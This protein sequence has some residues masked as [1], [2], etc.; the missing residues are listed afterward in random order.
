MSEL[1]DKK[2]FYSAAELKA[3]EIPDISFYFEPYVPTEGIMLLYG[4]PSGFKTTV[5]MAIANAM[6]HGTTLW[7]TQAV[8]TSP[9]LIV[10]LD[11][12]LR[13]FKT[14]YGGSIPD[15]TDMDFV[16]YK[17]TIDFVESKTPLDRQ[18]IAYFRAK[19]EERKYKAVFIDALRRC[20]HLDESKPET[21]SLVYAALEEVFHDC[22]LGI[23]HHSR[24]SGKDE[25]PDMA[26]ENYAGS[27]QWGAQ[28]QVAVQTKV[29]DRFLKKLDLEVTKSQVAEMTGPISLQVAG[30]RVMLES[31][32][33]ID[34]VGYILNGVSAGT[35]KDTV[36]KM[37]AEAE[38]V[39]KVTAKRR[40]LE[41]EKTQPGFGSV[42]PLIRA[43]DPPEG[44]EQKRVNG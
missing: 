15:S 24:K 18:L 14:R 43:I 28:A 12:P 23:N 32:V 19:H 26:L 7:G 10:E 30:W 29:T 41:W 34:R 9:I 39:S 25:T 2:I 20:H 22:V 5:M 36:D 27:I 6:A 3:L 21:P 4:K 33:K 31:D 8:K 35:S 40:R 44:T 17:A 1:D 11:T 42:V 13:T 37:I 38:G 16:F